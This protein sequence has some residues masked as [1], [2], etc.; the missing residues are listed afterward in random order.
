MIKISRLTDDD[1]KT[2]S[3]QAISLLSVFIIYLSG[4]DNNGSSHA[5]ND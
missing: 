5:S 3:R 1:K 4:P 2:L